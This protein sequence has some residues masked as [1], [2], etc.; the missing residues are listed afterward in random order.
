MRSHFGGRDWP[1]GAKG[2][3]SGEG[4]WP[5]SLH[6]HPAGRTLRKFARHFGPLAPC[7]VRWRRDGHRQAGTQN[8]QTARTANISAEVSGTNSRARGLRR[9]IRVGSGRLGAKPRR[10]PA[11]PGHGST[12]YSLSQRLIRISNE[13]FQGLSRPLSIGKQGRPETCAANSAAKSRAI[14]SRRIS[15]Q[16]QGETTAPCQSR[17]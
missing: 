1:L 13:V 17:M 11:K 14:G 4:R 7:V 8:R 16:L 9:R 6:N 12:D 5:N 2:S 15:T 10:R 3:S